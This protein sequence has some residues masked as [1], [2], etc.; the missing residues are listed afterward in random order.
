MVNK[1][2]KFALLGIM[3]VGLMLSFRSVGHAQFGAQWCYLSTFPP[4][5]C[6]DGGNQCTSQGLS[7]IGNGA[8][9]SCQ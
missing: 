1:I 8:S 7:C 2:A 5:G 6:I 3:S 4:E 9:C